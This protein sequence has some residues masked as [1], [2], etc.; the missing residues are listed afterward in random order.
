MFFVG[1]FVAVDVNRVGV[2]CSVCR[3]NPIY[4][5]CYAAVALTLVYEISTAFERICLW[6]VSLTVTS[7]LWRMYFFGSCL[8]ISLRCILIFTAVHELKY[9]NYT[10]FEMPDRLSSLIDVITTGGT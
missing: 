7:V 1:A 6:L 2:C 4:K 3:N 10:S 8:E 9:G 5:W